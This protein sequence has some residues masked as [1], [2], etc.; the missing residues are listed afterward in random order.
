MG[1]AGLEGQVGAGGRTGGTGAAG[2]PGEAGKDGAPGSV[3][4]LHLNDNGSVDPTQ[5]I[6]VV[7]EGAADIAQ[8]RMLMDVLQR[9]QDQLVRACM[10]AGGCQSAS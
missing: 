4:V 6:K 7:N 3:R 8:L 2:G 10:L 5:L 9:K 1:S